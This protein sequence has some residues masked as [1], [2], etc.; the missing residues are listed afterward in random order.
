MTTTTDTTFDG[1]RV[2][3]FAGHLMTILKGGLLSCMVDIGYRTGLFVAAAAGEA[4]S[5]EL[6]ARA[7]LEERYVREW[8]GAMVTEGI[9]EYDPAA[10]T[11][12][13]PPEHAALLTGPMSMAP[14]AQANTVLAKHVQQIV[15][16]FEEGGGV[17]YAEFC[18]E[19]SEALDAM[20]RGPLD[21]FLV[22]GYLPLAPGLSEKLSAGARVAEFA[23][24]AG[25]ALVL[26]ARAFPASTFVGYDLDE[27]AITRARAEAAGA[28]LSNVTFEV[29]DIARL[30]VDAPFDVV[31]MMDALHDQV[32]PRAVL[33]R[34]REALAP[35]GLFFLREPHA[36]DRLEDN[37]G[38]PTAP[39]MYSVST[40]HC[41]T[42]SLAH[43]GAGIGTAFGEGLARTLLTEAGFVPP[44][45]HPAPGTPF[46]AIYVTQVAV[47]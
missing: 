13:L 23:C 32:D 9:V 15:R 6:A 25:H 37:V 41:L 21:Q 28:E 31:F 42:V 1:S 44:A 2:E 40:L 39:I 26:L 16:V 35:H 34:V 17:P 19:F 27:G 43:G 18:P 8:L 10:Q 3:A 36:A 46:D 12:R 29:R 45:I 33:A 38:N 7:H 5:E 24:G 47:R 22:S 11:Y 30:R 14:I 4:T 20:G